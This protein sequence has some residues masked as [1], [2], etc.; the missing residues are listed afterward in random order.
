[1]LPFL[2]RQPEDDEV[3]AEQ[4]ERIQ[5]R[6]RDAEQRALVLRVEVPPE[7]VR[8]ELAVAQ[9]VGVD[10]HRPEV[11]YGW[12]VAAYTALTPMPYPRSL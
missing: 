11:V 5:Q 1:M 12:L 4:D 7:E 3:D 10:R 8:E 2:I 6:P 9:Q